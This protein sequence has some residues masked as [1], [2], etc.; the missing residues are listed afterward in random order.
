MTNTYQPLLTIHGTPGP[1]KW[2][3]V[4]P[5]D[6]KHHYAS[7]GMILEAA[8]RVNAGQTI[9]LGAGRCQEIPLL[10]LAHRFQRVVLNDREESLLM[11]ALTA[12][13]LA[14]GR[15]SKIERLVADLTGVTE[16]FLRLVSEYLATANDSES[17]ITELA[18]IAEA[19]QPTVFR[20]GQTYD[21]VVASCVLC[22]LHVAAC[23][24]VS[25]LFEARFPGHSQA[26]RTCE[27]WNQAVYRM[28]RRMEEACIDTI[29]HLLAP[30]GRIYLSDTV[31]GGFVYVTPEGRW[32]TDGLYRMTR[33]AQLTDYLD[34]RFQV[35]QRG[36]WHWIMDPAWEPGGV[37]RFYNVQGLVLRGSSPHW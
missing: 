35:E 27:N 13:G 37:G 3:Q 7:G 17:A 33:T 22:Q 28:A 1:R 2:V 10:E 18:S 24:R 12:S 36:R 23:N 21:L 29:C 9:I 8:S 15:G 31:Q 26:L 14:G 32:V 19:A 16:D 6:C 11:E 25:E 34:E 5:A 4:S 20:T 30:G